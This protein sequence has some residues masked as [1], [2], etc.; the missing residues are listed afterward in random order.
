MLLSDKSYIIKKNGFRIYLFPQTLKLKGLNMKGI[1]ITDNPLNTILNPRSIA[2][3]GASSDLSKPGALH[4]LSLI[5]TYQGKIYPVHPT[6]KEVLGLKAY[7][8][9]KELPEVV[10]LLVVMVPN[11][12]VPE[13]LIEAG[14]KGIKHA[15]I[16]TAGYSEM[17]EAG[18]ALQKEINDIAK[19]YGIRFLG[20]NCIGA[21]NPENGLNTTFFCHKK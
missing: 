19:R 20:P 14:E 18:D 2:F 21:V 16:I 6:K 13:L 15:I 8:S 1:D 11:S 9:I 12:V 17:G 10:D 4:L 3:V 5:G 7:S